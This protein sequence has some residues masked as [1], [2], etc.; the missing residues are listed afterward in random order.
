MLDRV[1]PVLLRPDGCYCASRDE[2]ED[3]KRDVV[4]NFGT[5]VHQSKN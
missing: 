5:R 3:E 2:D 4:P 1:K